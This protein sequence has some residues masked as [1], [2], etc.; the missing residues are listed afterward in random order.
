[1]DILPTS[2]KQVSA[3]IVHKSPSW[4]AEFTFLSDD[5]IVGMSYMKKLQQSNWALGGEIFYTA[6]EKSGGGIYRV[7]AAS[8]RT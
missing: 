8:F 5:Q 2:I 7:F 1:L 4:S 3:G 6:K